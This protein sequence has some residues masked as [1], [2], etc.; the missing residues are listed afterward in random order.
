MTNPEDVGITSE[1]ALVI[2]V[3]LQDACFMETFQR[4]NT[5]QIKSSSSFMPPSNGHQGFEDEEKS[6]TPKGN[7]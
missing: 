5:E 4:N 1:E 2:K 3:H 7:I 6:V